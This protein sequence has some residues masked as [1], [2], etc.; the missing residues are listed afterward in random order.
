MKGSCLCGVCVFEIPG[1]TGPRWQVPLYK[2]SKSLR[3]RLERSILGAAG[4]LSLV[5]G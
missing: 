5:I 3:H 1:D 4:Q 2:V